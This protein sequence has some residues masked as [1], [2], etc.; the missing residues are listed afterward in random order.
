MFRRFEIN[1]YQATGG[2]WKNWSENISYDGP[3]GVRF[4]KYPKTETDLQKLLLKARETGIKVRASGQRHSQPPQI[5]PD[6]RNSLTSSC[7]PL[8]SFI[9]CKKYN[10]C[11]VIDMSFYQDI[12]DDNNKIVKMKVISTNDATREAVVAVNAGI[13]E[14]EFTYFV[15]Q[16][17]LALKTV[18]AGGIFSMGG[19]TS[20]DV[21]GGSIN[22]GIFADTCEGFR[23]MKWDGSIMEVHEDDP[24][25]PD[26]FHPIQFARVNLGVLGIVTQIFVKCDFRATKQALQGRM[27]F[28]VSTIETEFVNAFKDFV[29]HHRLETF[30][31]PYTGG[32]LPLMWDLTDEY[33]GDGTPNMPIPPGR[34]TAERALK[35]H[36][37]AE[38]NGLVF[39]WSNSQ[40]KPIQSLIQ[41]SCSGI[42]EDRSPKPPAKAVAIAISQIANI[43]VTSAFAA[44]SETWLVNA[45]QCI[46]M[47]YFV[48]IPDLGE[49]GLAKTYQ[50]LQVVT[51]I[52]T[53]PGNFHIVAPMEFRFVRGGDSVM[54]GTYNTDPNTLFVNLDLIGFVDYCKKNPKNYSKNLLQFFAT[55]ERAWYGAGGLPHQ[56]KMYGFFDPNNSNDQSYCPPFNN[57]FINKVNARRDERA[58]GARQAFNNYRKE[59]DPNDMFLNE[60]MDKLFA[61]SESTSQS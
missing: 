7:L 26:G 8:P 32:F 30:Y 37:G 4:I 17:N 20:N 15:T 18:T 6:N 25:R 23:I 12:K 9:R 41:C 35:N 33:D 40:I 49:A 21:H 45:S 13:R 55:V 42:Q 54:A 53:K 1:R 27:A 34:T 22:S 24:V 44:Y 52:V 36:Y 14:D 3:R 16:N 48:E 58:P 28:L 51:D 43:Q 59:V 47:S 57:N 31:D 19:M 11:R 50:L 2:T 61:I 60:Y 46:F 10:E 38:L 56:G 39:K 5:V 29:Q